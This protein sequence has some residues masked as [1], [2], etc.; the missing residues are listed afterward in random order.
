MQHIARITSR[1]GGVAIFQTAPAAPSPARHSAG[2]ELQGPAAKGAKGWRKSSRR[3]GTL[4]P[5]WAHSGEEG[6]A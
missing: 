4:P 1:T 3:S 2:L 5:A 6:S